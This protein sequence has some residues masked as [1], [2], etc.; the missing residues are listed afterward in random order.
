MENI[1]FNPDARYCRSLYL[2]ISRSRLA[3]QD[4]A[5]AQAWLADNPINIIYQLLDPAEIPLTDGE[6]AAY[7]ALHTN[8]S[9][10]TIL[11]DADAHMSVEYA[12]DTKIYIDNKIA[13]LAAAI[14]GNA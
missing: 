5:G 11:N 8:K 4:A 9:D 1:G 10:T 6:I 7:R 13:G 3:T 2:R 12:A 14:L